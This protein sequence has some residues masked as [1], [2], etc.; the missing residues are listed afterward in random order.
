MGFAELRLQMEFGDNLPE[1]EVMK[2]TSAHYFQ[3]Y[4]QESV[5]QLAR[6]TN[7]DTEIAF[8]TGVVCDWRAAQG[9]GADPNP[10]EISLL[11]RAIK[12]RGLSVHELRTNKNG[13]T[14]MLYNYFYTVIKNRKKVYYNTKNYI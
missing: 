8:L 4:N 13:L 3:L 2:A 5:Q 6:H 7:R 14:V 9:L 10:I 11:R 12:S 1:K